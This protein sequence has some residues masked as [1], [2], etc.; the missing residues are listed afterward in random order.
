[1][2]LEQ[3][4]LL[5]DNNQVRNGAGEDQL[6]PE[7]DDALSQS[8]E[9]LHNQI[10]SLVVKEAYN[11]AGKKNTDLMLLILDADKAIFTL[12]TLKF[13]RLLGRVERDPLFLNCF[14]QN[15]SQSSLP[16]LQRNHQTSL[17][18]EFRG[19]LLLA[20]ILFSV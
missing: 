3:N 20:T 12:A 13:E 8:S 16:F 1:M 9:A 2:Y 15:P 6:L 7:L 17:D 19:T 11:L 14:E 18:S 10:R 4:S 5:I